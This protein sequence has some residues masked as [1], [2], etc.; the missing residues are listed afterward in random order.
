MEHAYA[1]PTDEILRFFNVEERS[2]LNDEQVSS[3]KA[4]Y[5]RNGEKSLGFGFL[6]IQ[7][8]L[9]MLFA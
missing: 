1:K 3:A 4:K 9:L 8:L 2:G 6:G 7:G 5:G